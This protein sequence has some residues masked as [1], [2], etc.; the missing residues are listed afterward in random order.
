M[1]ANAPAAG[2]SLTEAFRGKRLILAAS[3][4]GH[5]AQLDQIS[6]LIEPHPDSIWVTFDKPQ[7]RSL[8]AERRHEFVDYISPRDFRNM[9]KAR[10]T[11]RRLLASGEYEGIMSTGAAIALSALPFARRQRVPAVYVESVS[12]FDGPS[13]TGRIVSRLPGIQL[14][15]QH[16][17]WASRKWPYEFSV[18]DAFEPSGSNGPPAPIRRIFVTLGTIEPYRFDS[19][20]DAVLRTAPADAEIVWQLGCT[21]RRDLPGTSF[22]E[23]SAADFERYSVESDVVVTHSGVGSIMNLLALGSHVVV[24]PRRKSR[25]EH[26]DDHQE[27]VARDLGERGLCVVAEAPELTTADLVQASGLSAVPLGS[28]SS[29]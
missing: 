1:N 4:G 25:N 2:T 29:L 21:T 13:L 19:M 9:L 23:I 28:T 18:M 24:I 26:V 8:L 12:R 15:T 11:F 5:L 20:V 16:S 27:Q 10:S 6:R 22:T 7:S 14:R 17:E 3:T